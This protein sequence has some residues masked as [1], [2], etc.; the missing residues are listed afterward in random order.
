[1]RAMAIGM[2]LLAAAACA[3]AMTP[4]APGTSS[5]ADQLR[6][7]WSGGAGAPVF[8]LNQP[9]H[10]AVFVVGSGYARLL[11]APVTPRQRMGAGYHHLDHGLRGISGFGPF[12]STGADYLVAI[13][14]E[15]PL[16]PEISHAAASAA[17]LPMAWNTR[18]I[19]TMALTREIAYLALADPQAPWS[20]DVLRLHSSTPSGLA[21]GSGSPR[22][23]TPM[24]EVVCADGRRFM[25]PRG[26]RLEG[27]PAATAPRSPGAE[28]GDD[29]EGKVVTPPRRRP[30]P[31]ESGA[32][33]TPPRR[34]AATPTVRRPEAAPARQPAR[35]VR[36]RPA[37]E[38]Q[39]PQSTRPASPRPTRDAEEPNE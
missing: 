2:A 22:L 38:E 28:E 17:Y 25:V 12:G 1:M 16:R 18:S 23:R 8:W 20:V 6:V 13:A 31:A 34:P 39:R 9:A 33:T 10:V 7:R 27:C 26:Y 32:G 11:D 36:E 14:S 5:Q 21:Y 30:A 35:T 15:A 3:P 24:V 37:R 4:H 19:S 29:E